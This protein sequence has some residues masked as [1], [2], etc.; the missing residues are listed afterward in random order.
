M[1]KA[2]HVQIP[3]EVALQLYSQEESGTALISDAQNDK[4]RWYIQ[5]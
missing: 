1:D 5:N 2:P 3:S 4:E